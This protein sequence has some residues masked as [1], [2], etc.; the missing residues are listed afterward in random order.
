[1]IILDGVDDWP[2]TPKM[3]SEWSGFDK[4]PAGEKLDPIDHGELKS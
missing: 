1:M 3:Y 4:R 2:E